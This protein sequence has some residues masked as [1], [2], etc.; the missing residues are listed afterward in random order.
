[1]VSDPLSRQVVVAPAPANSGQSSTDLR[2]ASIANGLGDMTI[3]GQDIGSLGTNLAIETIALGVMSSLFPIDLEPISSQLPRV[4]AGIAAFLGPAGLGAA[5][6]ENFNLYTQVYLITYLLTYLVPTG[7]CLL[8]LLPAA[9]CLLPAGAYWL[10]LAYL[11][12]T[13]CQV[14]ALIDS[15]EAGGDISLAQISEIT[16]DQL[17]G[18][19]F[20]LDSL[21]CTPTST[22]TSLC[23]PPA[24]GGAPV[25]PAISVGGIQFS[26]ASV[27]LLELQ[28]NKVTRAARLKPLHGHSLLILA[29]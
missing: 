21:L 12:P 29:N 14:V 15:I 5:A 6:I 22:P 13:A 17:A 19:T 26:E 8:S 24:G 7:Y 28:L 18:K 25:A 23:Q 9:R 11:L 2:S 4:P 16:G 27:E 1:M 3:N 20:S 10:L